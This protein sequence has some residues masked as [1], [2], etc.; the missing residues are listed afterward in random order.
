MPGNQVED[1]K[2]DPP[3]RV[4][5]SLTHGRQRRRRVTDLP[6]TSMSRA[7][8]TSYNGDLARSNSWARLRRP[9]TL[10]GSWEKDAPPYAASNS[11]CSR[12]WI[13]DSASPQR[14]NKDAVDISPP[15]SD[16]GHRAKQAMQVFGKWVKRSRGNPVATRNTDMKRGWSTAE[17]QL[18][19][20]L[21][22]KWHR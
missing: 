16:T 3:S 9:L 18:T 20:L 6:F 21:T 10:S 15:A 4:A 14:A 5:G 22:S 8:S 17:H 11:A 1:S 13:R 2:R 7:M 12:A 19:S